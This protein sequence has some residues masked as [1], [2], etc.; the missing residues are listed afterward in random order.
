MKLKQFS[1]SIGLALIVLSGCSNDET[2]EENLQATVDAAVQAT[3][4]V[5]SPPTFTPVPTV[6]PS[7]TPTEEPGTPT[8]T[9]TA[10]SIPTETPTP[11]PELP[12]YQNE[13][14]DGSVH[15]ELPFE[16]FGMTLPS[17]WVV[18][19]VSQTTETPEQAEVQNL[20]GS[21]LF[22]NLI[23]SGVKFYAINWS[24][25][26]RSSVSPANINITTQPAEGVESLE[27]F[28][29]AAVN[30]LVFQFDLFPEDISQT[31]ASIGENPALRLDYFWDLSTP[32]GEEVNLQ[33]VQ[34]ILIV[35]DQIFI[36]T[37]TIPSELSASLLPD[38]ESAVQQM[39]FVDN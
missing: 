13:L 9:P 33:V 11:T 5:L 22:Q 36:I 7:L 21:G 19:D 29:T 32:T 3:T 37:V 30:Q 10:T 4:E 6:T 27:G 35:N 12:F 39:T 31:A 16:G 17:D 34:H 8:P 24:E 20:L 23:R 26:S 38:A 2:A 1:L 28:G 18:I 14:E 15:Y 25:P